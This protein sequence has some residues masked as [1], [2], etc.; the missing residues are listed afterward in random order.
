MSSTKAT[1]TVAA[2]GALDAV[3]TT[4]G[5][6]G[7]GSVF[8]GWGTTTG[9]G[10]MFGDWGTT[11]SNAAQT[12]SGSLTAANSS[13]SSFGFAGRARAR[14]RRTRVASHTVATADDN[15][16]NKGPGTGGW[17]FPLRGLSRRP[18]PVCDHANI[19]PR[20]HREPSL[21]PRG[22]H[23]LTFVSCIPFPS[24]ALPSHAL[25]SHAN[26][27]AATASPLFF[28]LAGRALIDLKLERPYLRTPSFQVRA[29]R[30]C[31]LALHPHIMSH[32]P[33]ACSHPRVP[34]A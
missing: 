22:S 10:S 34:L 32:R 29:Y 33:R 2:A 5:C 14:A 6:A 28:T 4:D 24:H 19:Y 3:D 12:V 30:R 16:N 20:P 27:N 11:A 25:P 26:A 23:A 18:W 15:D 1:E 17:S 13:L 8:G 7:G 9:S 31:H 21:S